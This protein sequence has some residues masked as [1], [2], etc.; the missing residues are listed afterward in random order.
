MQDQYA[1][2][3]WGF[4]LLGIIANLTQGV[5]YAGSVASKHLMNMV[6]IADP[7]AVKSHWG[8][9][10]TLTIVFLP[11]GM[12]VAGRLA[13]KIGPR[14]PIL[15]GGVIFGLGLILSSFTT[16][17]SVFCFTF[18]FMISFGSGLAYGPI[19]ASAVRWFPDRRG[20][21]S[22]LVVG[23]L[24][25]GPVWISPLCAKLLASGCDITFILQILG[26][27]SMVA[28]CSASFITS[29][30]VDFAESLAKKPDKSKTPV[31]T[32]SSKLELN[33][34]KMLMRYEF[35]ILAFLFMMGG[36]PGL[37]LL[38]QASPIF[39]ELGG[40]TATSVAS[41][42]AVLAAANAFGRVLWGYISDRL[43][44]LNTL[45]VMFVCSA[46]AMFILPYATLPALLVAVILVIGTTFGGYLGLFP[47]FCADAFGLKNLSLNYA[48]LFIAFSIAAFVG[49]RLFVF[50]GQHAAFNAAAVLSL[51]GCIVSF[52]YMFIRRKTVAS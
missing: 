1:W 40:F 48:V 7:D 38:S 9:A 43:G 10:F 12:I 13:D 34:I 49:P 18:G 45:A 2:K 50:L 11:L 36:I 26:A 37:M 16:S 41:L 39:S 42:V 51:L 44:R 25:F 15:L 30:P 32:D 8:F 5:A 6:Q 17:Y 33:W 27:I 29:P 52:A 3:R 19:V 28:I 35:W 14:I 46:A 23:A 31:P 20:L 22:G 4:L 24:G 21:A 47:S